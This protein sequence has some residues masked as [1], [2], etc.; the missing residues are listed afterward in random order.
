MIL[1]RFSSMVVLASMAAH[2]RADDWPQWGGPQRDNVWRESGILK[3]L[4]SEMKAKWRTPIN[5][6]YAGPAV[7]GGKVFVTDRTLGEG[8]E[9]PENPFS[10]SPVTGSERVLCLDANTGKELWKHEYPCIYTV[11]Y[12]NG[13]R[14]TPMADGNRVYTLGTMGDFYCLN[15]ADGKVIWSKNF[16]KE[17]GGTLNTW[18]FSSAPL[19]DGDK[20]ICIAGGKDGDC[21]VA[22]DKL[23]GDVQWKS[24]DAKDFGYCPPIIIEAGGARQLI[25]WTPEEI[26]SL[27]PTNGEVYWK[28]EFAVKAGLAI[29]TPIHDKERNLLFITSFYNGP[30]M[31]DLDPKKP[32][33]KVRWRGTSQSELRTDKLHAIMCTPQFWEGHIY[34]VC[35]YG[36]LRCLKADDGT[37]LWETFEA[38]GKA[39]WWNAFLVRNEDRFFLANEQGELLL[40]NLSPKGYVEHGRFKMLEPTTPLERSRKIVWSHPAFANRSVY[41]RNDKEIVC[42]DLSDR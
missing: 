21:V 42:F 29:P 11:S 38:T 12:P 7:A 39:R 10:K 30:I 18:G 32:A 36:Q 25:I 41:A 5:M 33:A 8:S 19:I 31:F 15:A 26:A 28:E 35:S 3:K 34:G 40:A 27:N 16:L 37:R 17:F 2:L 1:V 23:K 4:P 24:M 6:G 22:F 14:A 13:P 20:V 9:N